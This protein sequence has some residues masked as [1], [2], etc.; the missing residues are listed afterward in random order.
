ML[1]PHYKGKKVKTALNSILIMGIAMI[2]LNA[3]E[4]ATRVDMMKKNVDNDLKARESYEAK[5]FPSTCA[6][7]DSSLLKY[8]FA[9]A[10]QELK[11]YYDKVQNTCYGKL[12][13]MALHNKLQKEGDSVC[14]S[15]EVTLQIR[16]LKSYVEKTNDM[17]TWDD[18]MIDYKKTC[19]NN[20]NF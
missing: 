19:P 5:K 10:P 7:L 15:M 1:T 14:K 12:H 4:I 9:E 13:I 3:T 18:F 8:T 20:L 6:R 11:D 17:Q 2:T 16:H